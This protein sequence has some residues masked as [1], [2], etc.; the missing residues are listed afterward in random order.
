M[1]FLQGDKLEIVV[2]SATGIRREYM[3]LRRD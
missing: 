3:D 2:L 1:D